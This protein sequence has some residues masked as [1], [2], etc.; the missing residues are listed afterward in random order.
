MQ[1]HLVGSER[2]IGTFQQNYE[3]DS[4]DESILE[5]GNKVSKHQK[6]EEID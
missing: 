4:N 2:K 6:K 1:K 5:R 3:A